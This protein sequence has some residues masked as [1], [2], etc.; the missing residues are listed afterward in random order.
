MY[1]E[2]L[3]MYYDMFSLNGLNQFFLDSLIVDL[4]DLL[5]WTIVSASFLFFPILPITSFASID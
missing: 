2:G 5:Y 1:P 3:L 4:W